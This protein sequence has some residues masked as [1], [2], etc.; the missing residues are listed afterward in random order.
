MNISRMNIPQVKETAYDVFRYACNNDER[1]TGKLADFY[2]EGIKNPAVAKLI[3]QQA[4][5]DGTLRYGE[6]LQDD[7]KS[8]R[9]KPLE[10]M[11]EYAGKMILAM[12]NI[13][14]GI[15]NSTVKE[16]YENFSQKFK[17]LYPQTH[18]LREKI[19]S[20]QRVCLN[21]INPCMQ[22]GIKKTLKFA[23]YV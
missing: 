1:M 3:A 10:L 18:R 5:Q 2:R 21:K 14:E 19:L 8:L 17:Q 7:I 6:Y 15:E 13:A 16:L 23:R 9:G 20:E 22:K 11:K 12:T 4:I